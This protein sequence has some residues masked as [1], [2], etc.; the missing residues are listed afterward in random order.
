MKGALDPAVKDCTSADHYDY[1]KTMILE[2]VPS[3]RSGARRR[4]R[5]QPYGSA[6]DNLSELYEKTWQ[7]ARWGIVLMV[8]DEVEEF[9][10]NLIEA[11]QGRV[12]KQLPNRTLS[13]EGRP[14][15]AMLIANAAGHKYEHPPAL[16]PRHR[17][18]AKKSRWW[19]ARHPG[20]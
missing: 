17:Q 7:D 14:I 13:K 8:S 10:G 20:I 12:A 1:L 18:V 19:R 6:L 11:P 16:Q 15:H 2:G 4:T 3:R 5:T 9:L